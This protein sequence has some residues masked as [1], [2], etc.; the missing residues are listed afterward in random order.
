MNVEILAGRLLM[1][2][3]EMVTN[4]NYVFVNKNI[5]TRTPPRQQEQCGSWSE[6]NESHTRRT[7]AL[8]ARLILP[9]FCSPPHSHFLCACLLSLSAGRKPPWARWR[10][11]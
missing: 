9:L 10:W 11:S 5:D 6:K 2:F 7:H 8:A 4:T 3:T 1:A